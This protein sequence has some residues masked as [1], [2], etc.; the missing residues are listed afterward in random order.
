[1]CTQQ[2][3]KKNKER[4]QNARTTVGEGEGKQG[5]GEECTYNGADKGLRVLRIWRAKPISIV[6][7]PSS[8]YYSSFSF[9]KVVE[10]IPCHYFLSYCVEYK[11]AHSLSLPLCICLP[12]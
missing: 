5:E 4:V 12:Q 1:M 9:Y 6:S 8:S 11:L 2:W 3:A 7:L 10:Y